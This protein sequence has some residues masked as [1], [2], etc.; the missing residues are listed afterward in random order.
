[1]LKNLKKLISLINPNDRKKVYALTVLMVVTAGMQT[2]GIASIMP[3]LNI[4]SDVSKIESTPWISALFQTLNFKSETSF[5]YALGITS[6][7][8]FV[9]GT[10]LQA[11]TFWA[12][13]RFTHMQ[14]YELSKRLMQDY[15][16]R[17][18]SFY[19]NRNS[20][21]LAKTVL[22][23]T[24]QAINGGLLPAMRLLSQVLLSIFIIS[25]I[26]IINPLL[27]LA[28][29]ASIASVYLIIYLAARNWLNKIGTDRVDANK[30]RYTAT[31]EAF[32]G[33]KEIRLLGR[34]GNYLERYRQ[35]AKR[36]A[37][38]EANSS[39]LND[40]PQYAIEAFV[41][42]G[43]LI[44]VTA[45]ISMEGGLENAI[46]IIGVYALAARQLIPAFHKIFSTFSAI[47]YNLPAVDNVLKDLEGNTSAH[48]QSENKNPQ[49]KIKPEKEIKIENIHFC[50]PGS[51]SPALSGINVCIKANSTLGIIG[52]SGSG[53][54]TLIDVL[55]GLLTP[56]KGS[57]RIDE[58][59]LNKDNI[60]QWQTSIG[61]VPQ[62]I[63]LADQSIKANIALGLP[64]NQID[65]AAVI[66]AA[67]LAELHEF[68]TNDL[69]MKYDT[70][71]GERGLRISG[72]QRQRIGI[73]RA[74]YNDPSV[75]IF[76]EATSA[77]DNATEKAVMEAIHNLS[78]KKTIILVAHRLSTV[79]PCHK[80]IMLDKGKVKI[81]GD[82]EK[83][84]NIQN[85]ITNKN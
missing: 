81:K 9:T 82:W 36:L 43:V 53:K 35:P 45:L 72:G 17:P 4:L 69:P 55:L 31:A 15:L 46:P 22:H 66:R 85:N 37:K 60:R 18:Y 47:R 76:D 41:F 21:D 24:G 83:I 19:L 30:E 13:V 3:F 75:L 77:L 38:H 57:I 11:I 40:I 51:Q 28:I 20:S 26:L 80:I 10:A 64:D 5:L 16:N 48:S 14:Q 8:L 71:I 49:T 23:E 39:L 7:I 33:A 79:E 61:Y 78:G 63:F 27:S 70:A 68:I 84:K 54:S 29:A 74:L 12:I 6:F 58:K 2:I 32:T 52:H 56:E 44:L 73:A 34:E 65:D 50:Y 42:G 62:N 25:L 59:E 1:M 67:K